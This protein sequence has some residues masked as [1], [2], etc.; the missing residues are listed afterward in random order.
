MDKMGE[1]IGKVVSN[2]IICNSPIHSS[3]FSI[4][5]DLFLYI[6]V[7]YFLGHILVYVYISSYPSHSCMK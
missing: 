2:K 4:Y 3:A 5:P 7:R 6:P 1:R